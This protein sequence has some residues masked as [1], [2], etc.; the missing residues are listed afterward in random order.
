MRIAVWAN[1]ELWNMLN[2][3]GNQFLS[4]VDHFNNQMVNDFDAF[5]QLIEYNPAQ[6]LINSSG[7]PYFLNDVAGF[8]KKLSND[9]IIRFNGWN[10]FISKPAWEICGNI[11]TDA[12]AVLEQINKNFIAVP[13]VPG[14]ISARV[15]SMIINEAYFALEEKVSSKTDIDTAM[16]L[17]TNYPYGPFEWCELIGKE[18]VYQLLSTLAETNPVY[19]PAPL[20]KKELN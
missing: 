17:G 3:E 15:I 13:D 2:P 10:G 7:K 8:S 14:M 5:I 4:R 11:T 1:D 9:C 18:N 12:R 19:T 20:L 16:K 6:T